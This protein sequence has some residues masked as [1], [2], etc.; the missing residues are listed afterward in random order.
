[1]LASLMAAAL[2][3]LGTASAVQAAAPALNAVIKLRP[4]TPTEIKTY[5]LTNPP[6][7]F[8]AGLTTV[9]LGEPVYVDAMVNVAIAPSNIVGVVWTLTNAPGSAAT[10]LPPILGT[11]VPLYNSSDLVRGEKQTPF[12]QLAGASGRAFF[13][14]DV[15]GP[16]TLTAT[17]TVAAGAATIT[18]TNL[19]VTVTAGTFLGVQTCAGCHSGGTVIG[20]R[21]APNTYL[22]YTNTPHASMFTRAID[23]LVSSHY[24]KSCIV[25][26]TTGYDTNSF[27]INQGFDDIATL[28]GWTFPAVLTNGNWA[29]MPQGLKNVAN[30]TCENC[31]GPGSQHLYS[32]GITGNTNAITVSYNAGACAQCH[33]SVTGHIKSAEWNNSLHAAPSSTPTGIT[34]PACVR[35]H[36]GPGFIGWAKAGGMDLQVQ[37]PTNIIW[38]DYFSTNIVAY[39]TNSPTYTTPQTP[40]NTTY[41][42]INCQTC[43]DP[44]NASNPHELRKQL[45]V[46]LSDGTVVT[47]AGAGGFCMECHNSRNGSVAFMMQQYPKNQPNWITGVAFGTHDSPQADMLE[48]VNAITYGKAIANAPHKNVVADT[49]AGCHMQA[50][51][52]TIVVN[53]VTNANPAF[54]QAGGHTFKMDY[55]VTNNGVVTEVPLTTVCVQCHGTITDFDMLVPDYAGI[56]QPAGIQTQ[57]QLLLNKL[58]TYY[59]PSGYQANANNYVADGKIKSSLSTYTNMPQ[60]FLNAAYNFQF[61]QMDNSFGVHNGPFAVGLLKASIA[62]LTGDGNNDGLSDAW[63]TMVY[64]PNFYTNTAASYSAMNNGLPNWMW[65]SMNLIPTAGYQPTGNNGVIYISNGTV[66][67]GQTNTVAIYTAAEIAF[68]TQ[69]GVTYTVQGVSALTGGWQNVSTNIPGTGGVVSFLTPTR[70]NAQMFYRVSHVP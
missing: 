49:C 45:S 29:A 64:G 1:M 66:A 39:N 51:S 28:Y 9:A 7:Q 69:V 55:N 33:D 52:P 23:G 25:C 43:H 2:T 24:N 65:A 60:K 21:A 37:Y 67:N 48:G 26:H 56:G 38:A 11:N 57:V 59:P 62:D 22:T 53:G 5:N 46:T 54:L 6:A 27:A 44:H 20:G 68:N 31:H 34:R 61:V 63:Q 35:C 8:S 30:I 14:P 19:T 32:Q 13:R 18:T 47:N 40:P 58:S 36:T 16:Y 42:A 15:V 4:L 70:N 10:L 17:I 12:A 50:V 41:E 3:L